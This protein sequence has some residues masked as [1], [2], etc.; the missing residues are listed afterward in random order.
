MN[1]HIA[2]RHFGAGRSWTWLRRRERQERPPAWRADARPT[3]P[4]RFHPS[5]RTAA[6]LMSHLQQP[7]GSLG[8]P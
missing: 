6:E 1:V 8:D 3:T 4:L 2:H 5:L 7:A